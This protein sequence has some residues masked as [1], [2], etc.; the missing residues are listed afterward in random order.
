MLFD[1]EIQR[2]LSEGV[3]DFSF[4]MRMSMGGEK[5]LRAVA[6]V[7]EGPILMGIVQDITESKLAEQ[8]LRR[9]AASLE[10]GQ[11]LSKTGSYVMLSSGG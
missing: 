11:H 7:I 1:A 9:S 3:S 6:R 4:R 10:E 8:E 2:A 5:Y